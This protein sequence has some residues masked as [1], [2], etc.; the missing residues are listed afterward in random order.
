V[1]SL[2][3]KVLNFFSNEHHY[4]GGEVTSHLIS[5]SSIC[6]VML[7]YYLYFFVV[8]VIRKKTLI[9]NPIIE[10]RAYDKG[11]ITSDQLI[12]KYSA[13][14][15]ASSTMAAL[16]VTMVLL[17]VAAL[18]EKQL[19]PYNHFIAVLVCTL[20]TVAS[21]ALLYAHELY[22]AII[23]PLFETD[24]R[25]R[26]RQLGSNFQAFGLIMFIFSML[27]AVSTVSTIST[28]ISCIAVCT[29]MFIYIEK[30]L[31]PQ[32]NVEDEIEKAL[33][34]STGENMNEIIYQRAEIKDFSAIAKLDR[35]A[36]KLNRNSQF[37]PDGEH[38][39]RLWVEHGLVYV[40]KTSTQIEGAI[41]AFPC[42]S[43]IWCVHK[44]F[45]LPQLRGK[46][47]GTKLFEI[48][49]T[50]TDKMK[51]KCFLTVDPSNTAALKLYEK[52]GFTE[53]VFVQGYYQLN[54]DRYVLTR[55]PK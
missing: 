42:I 11:I 14:L 27:L 5:L 25:F 46:G 9:R 43:G 12:F 28:F 15:G 41:L 32:K 48:L 19:D 26:L 50:E 38:V 51:V 1:V 36:W 21:A 52:W 33:G 30:R 55:S 22:D 37:I 53:K 44:V 10:R 20:M 35:E 8:V 47:V 4:F 34:I 45:V 6:F 7:F 3:Q 24:K 13:N 49:L 40:A 29:F 16:S 17:S 31:I 23:N 18:F 54:E 39:W 2:L